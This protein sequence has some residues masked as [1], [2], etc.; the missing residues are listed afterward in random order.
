LTAIRTLFVQIIFSFIF[1]S[2]TTF[3][4]SSSFTNSSAAP[5]DVNTWAFT[6]GGQTNDIFGPSN[7]HPPVD[8]PDHQQYPPVSSNVQPDPGTTVQSV[9]DAHSNTNAQLD[10]AK[11]TGTVNPSQ[12]LLTHAQ[13]QAD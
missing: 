3:G 12:L 9:A 4:R 5:S 13:Q 11:L 7:S 1:S 10:E 6:S 8:I 2:F